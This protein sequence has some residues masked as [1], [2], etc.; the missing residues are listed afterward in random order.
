MKLV[1]LVHDIIGQKHSLKMKLVKLVPDIIGQKHSLKMKLV[2][3]LQDII[4]QKHSFKWTE[5]NAHTNIFISEE[6]VNYVV[7]V[8]KKLNL[9][10]Q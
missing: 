2:K 8:I 4:G 7:S 9:E 1:K 6:P 10:L 3:L 5:G